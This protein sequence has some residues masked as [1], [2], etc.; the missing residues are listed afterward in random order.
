MI[1][2]IY[3]RNDKVILDKHGVF[4]IPTQEGRFSWARKKKEIVFIM[5]YS[6]IT[7]CDA[8]FT[9]FLLFYISLSEDILVCD[10]FCTNVMR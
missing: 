3:H 10:I 2:F 1:A 4:G 6:P 8:A 5:V 9:L 7:A